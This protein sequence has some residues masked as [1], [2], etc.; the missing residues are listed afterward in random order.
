MQI[1]SL[2]VATQ[3]NGET[4]QLVK[5]HIQETL[6][7]PNENTDTQTDKNLNQIYWNYIL[8]TH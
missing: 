3:H 8:N 5:L 6:N 7:S 2:F 1:L 4:G